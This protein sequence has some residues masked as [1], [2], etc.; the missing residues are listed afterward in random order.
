MIAGVLMGLAILGRAN[1]IVVLL[2]L[3]VAA[4]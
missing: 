3:A 4:W 2:P 1:A